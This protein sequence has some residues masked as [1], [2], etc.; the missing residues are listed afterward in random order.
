MLP[1]LVLTDKRANLDGKEGVALGIKYYDDFTEIIIDPDNGDFIGG[2]ETV[3][4]DLPEENGGLEKGMVR[5]SY[6]VTSAVVSSLG[7]RSQTCNR[8]VAHCRVDMQLWGCT[9]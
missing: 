2:R 9:C 3:A 6:A 5:R 4:E 8:G 1:G 7:A